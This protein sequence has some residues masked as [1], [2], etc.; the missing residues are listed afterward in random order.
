MKSFETFLSSFLLI[1]IIEYSFLKCYKRDMCFETSQAT[2]L[3]GQGNN[4]PRNEKI[5]ER[6]LKIRLSI[7]EQGSKRFNFL[8]EFD[9]LPVWKLFQ[10]NYFLKAKIWVNFVI[11]STQSYFFLFRNMYKPGS[12]FARTSI[13]S[14]KISF[15]QKRFPWSL[16]SITHWAVILIRVRWFAEKHW[17]F[18][19]N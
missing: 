13:F 5:S 11:R 2:T 15:V 4:F 6:C 8:I 16:K 14:T 18:C 12:F 1:K 3:K 17:R 7:C 19:K 9:T 10:L